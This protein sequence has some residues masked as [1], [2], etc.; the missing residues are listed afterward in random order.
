MN[1][2]RAALLLLA[3]APAALAAQRDTAR[4]DTS[5]VP[6]TAPIP[7][8]G[9]P[10][11]VTTRHSVTIGGQR[12]DYD[13]TVGNVI[14]QDTAGQPIASIFYTAYTRRGVR[15]ASR[16]PITFAY[17]GGPGS[18]SVWLHMGALG[19]RRVVTPDTTHA[20]P[21]PY[22]I[23]DNQYS[24][25]DRTDLV[26]IDPV[27]T[28]Y[29][30]AIGKAT[31]KDF[32]GVDEDVR[33]LAQFISRYLSEHGRWNSPRYLAGE[34]YGTTRSAAL[35]NYL[36]NEDNMDFNGVILIS[37]VL[38]FQT[39]AFDPGNLMPYVM[40]LPGYTA[41]AWYHRALPQQP[42]ELGPL[43]Q[44][45]ERFATTEYARA[46]MAGAT[47]APAERTRILDRLHRYTGLSQAY[48]D[49][50]DLR[51][52]ASQFEKQLLREHGQTVGR[53]D[54]RFTGPTGNPLAE[55]PEYDPQSAAVSSAYTSAF[56]QYLH[57]ELNY[58]RD[59]QYT[60]SGEVQ[61]WNWTHGRQRGWPGHT[62][63]ATD[64]AEAIRRNPRLQVQL[65]SGI[66]DLATPYY[67]AEWTMDQLQLPPELRGNVHEVRYD[68]GH[69][70]Y[71]YEPALAELWRNITGFIDR[72]SGVGA[73]ERRAAVR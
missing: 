58:G 5:R 29:S 42:A 16:R 65:H 64:L 31:G 71:L 69:M 2:I 73:G 62:N 1:P 14:L 44:E 63:V 23:V 35:V 27:G 47:L 39:I 72:T 40:Y 33:S 36:Q 13:A 54:A 66:Y 17:N 21:P 59:K 9:R 37:A 10:E 28:G 24:P 20:P 70:M 4:A 25:L 48:L 67:A 34:S 19:P 38:D 6:G 18:S 41:V 8:L 68:A 50:A 45:V 57:T 61:P 55:R 60:I 49:A 12:V 3:L 51:V 22:P 43:L 53:L 15:D 46:L 30:R 11:H 7:A 26:F 56:N 32:W 52:D